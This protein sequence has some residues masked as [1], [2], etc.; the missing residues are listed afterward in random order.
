MTEH[1]MLGQA[2]AA[3]GLNP[4]QAEAAMHAHGPLVIFA[5][6]GSGK[7][8]TITRRCANLIQRH[9]I[10]PENILLV[11]FTNK[12][13]N[14][15]KERMESML[16]KGQLRG[17]W[18]GTFHS[19]CARML[20]T[21]AEHAHRRKDFVIYD[22]H[23]QEVVCRQI[24]NE[25]GLDK[26]VFPPSGLADKIQKCKQEALTDDDL[27]H[28]TAEE[29]RFIDIRHRYE[30]WMHNCN[31]LDFE[32]LIL[33]TMQLA[34]GD[35]EVGDKLRGR[36]S[37]VLVDEFQDTNSTQYRLVRA[38]GSSRN[39]CVVGDDD[40]CIYTWR[41]ARVQN[42]RG[43]ATDYPEAKVVKLEQNYRSTKHIVAAALG[44][45]EPSEGRTPKELWTANDPGSRV[46]IIE[47]PDDRQEAKFLA[48]K[49]KQ[50]MNVGHGL[51]GMAILYRTHAQSRVIE[52]ELRMWSVPYRVVGGFRFY[53]RK[54]VKDLLSYIRLIANKDSDVDLLRIIN[55]PPRGIG[56]GTAK[57]IGEVASSRG[58]SLWGALPYMAQ[59]P[60]LRPKE[61]S[62]IGRFRQ[63]IEELSGQAD[64]VRA[65][66]LAVQV[67]M[68][69]GYK[70]M[71][72]DEARDFR[73]EG[74][75]VKAE[76]AEERAANCDEVVEAIAHYE[77]QT[78][79]SGEI[80]TLRGYLEMVSLIMDQ[81][82]NEAVEKLTLM[83][84][85]AA[86]GLEFPFVWIVGAEE[87]H[88][89]HG[90][91][92]KDEI[93]ESQRLLY[94]AITRAKKQLWITHAETRWL[95]GQQQYKEPSRFLALIPEANAVRM[96]L[97]EYEELERQMR[98]RAGSTAAQV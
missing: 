78:L 40:Q 43:F 23:D 1:A 69:T 32:D 18:S 54:E 58:I 88:F 87:G 56:A 76:E 37:H 13:A 3:P 8:S 50:L 16:G 2:S 45:I 55:E 63:M 48:A 52:E 74:Q 72:L 5:G 36:F 82:K 30:R 35:T 66:E 95:H 38:F 80:P 9:G 19:V 28:E 39:I 60:E 77:R 65:S 86:K 89:P 85:H 59:S 93:A 12:A 98:L 27:P 70:T 92:D 10:K 75:R 34:E 26:K 41:G 49:V 11:T 68:T 44:V 71:W 29:I 7:T 22:S 97:L 21:Y 53:D 51:N 20:R 33:L 14:E 17:L 62:Q 47:M 64:T 84:V 91:A 81:E 4:A 46:A 24:V 15:M 57:R 61:Q 90:E 42:I 79:E 94:V 6:A 31:A 83:T 73:Q 67:V 25:L 96:T